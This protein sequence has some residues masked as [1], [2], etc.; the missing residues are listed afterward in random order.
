MATAAIQSH[1]LTSQGPP[2]WGTVV[3]TPFVL[4]QAQL[5]TPGPQ[6]AN[7][8]SPGPQEARVFLPG[9]IKGDVE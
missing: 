9:K 1:F 3:R 2:E 7:V 4:S 5:F 6:G 8:F